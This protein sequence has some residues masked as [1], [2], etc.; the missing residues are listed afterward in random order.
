M[1]LRLSQI[2]YDG[3]WYNDVPV[4]YDLL[5]NLMVSS[6]DGILY[7]IRS[8][9]LTDVLLSNHHFIYVDAHKYGNLNP[10]YYDQLYNGKSEVLVK[11]ACRALKLAGEVT[12]EVY[13]E[14]KDFIYIKKG[15]QYMPVTGKG[16]LLN[17][18]SDKSEQLKQYLSAN[19][20]NFSK[21]KENTIV[22]LAA[23]Y[24]QAKN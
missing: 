16:S 6:A 24:D 13:Y 4:F 1:T 3:V 12:V 20:M 2:R 14:N 15:G 8:D 11:R 10:G 18:L 5:N 19:R 17:I 9:K 21:D 22:R 7:G 23:Y